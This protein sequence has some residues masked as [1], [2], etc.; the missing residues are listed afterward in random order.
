MSGK[1]NYSL[2]HAQDNIFLLYP[3]RS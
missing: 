1:F 2:K 3:Y